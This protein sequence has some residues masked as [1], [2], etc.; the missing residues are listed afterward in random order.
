MASMRSYGQYCALA[1]ALDVIG[2]RWTLLIVRELLIRGACRYTDLRDGLPG[3]AT[4]LLVERLRELEEAG[5]IGREEAP[6][7]V[8]TALF[9]LTE[10][11]EALEIVLRELGR[12]GAPLLANAPKTDAFR[13]HWL[14]LPA[15]EW[16]RDH[17]PEQPAILIE[18]RAGDQSAVVEAAEGTVRIRAGGTAHPDAVISGTP[19]LLL[20]L[21]AGKIDL[22][23]ARHAGVS[24]KGD[25]AVLGRVRPMAV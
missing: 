10:R 8:A 21:L 2:D 24:Y 6:P 25:P 22:A 19:Q 16:L 14:A 3:I 9:R 5:V 12:W 23:Q 20:G 17:A 4:N 13:G 18:L 1:K 7:P 15:G 11:G